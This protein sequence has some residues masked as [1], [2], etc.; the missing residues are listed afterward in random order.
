LDLPLAFGAA[1]REARKK[2]NLSQEALAEKCHFDRT[3]ISLIERGKRQP[4][5]S[6]IFV[7]AIALEIPPHL[8]IKRTSEIHRQPD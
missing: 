2:A 5:L 3:Y 4:L 7:F 8:L 6:S 1:I